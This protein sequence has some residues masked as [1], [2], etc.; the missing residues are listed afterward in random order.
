[1]IPLRDDIPSRTFPFVTLALILANAAVFVYQ[2]GLGPERQHELLEAAAAV[3]ENIFA[4]G[5]APGLPPYLRLATSLF[6][7]GG[8][9]H[10]AGNMLFLWIFGDNVEDRMG[11]LPFAFFYLACGIAAAL[12]HVWHN[13]DSSIPLIGAS[14]A[15]SGI[16]GAY[17]LLFPGARIQVLIV[18]IIFITTIKVPALVFIGGWAALQ[19]INLSRGSPQIA[20]YAHIGGFVAGAVITGIGV[21]PRGKNG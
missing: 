6:L 12:T 15:V 10:I 2:A 17:I 7:H 8:L 11:H 9:M 1:M 5:G 16:L 21:L 4:G 3:P 14:G 19:F 18:L 20:W 13:P